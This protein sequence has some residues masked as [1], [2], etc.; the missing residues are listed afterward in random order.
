MKLGNDNLALIIMGIVIFLAG[1]IVAVITAFTYVAQ[2]SIPEF[3]QVLQNYA[4]G[5]IIAVVLIV[6]GILL[7][8]AGAKS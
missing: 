2:A 5:A 3:L 1:V 4:V 6:V 8:I 7:M